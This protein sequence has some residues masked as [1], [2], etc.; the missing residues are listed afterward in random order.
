MEFILRVDEFMGLQIH[1]EKEFITITET[2]LHRKSLNQS[3]AEKIKPKCEGIK[4]VVY[5][6]MAFV[7]G[8]AVYIS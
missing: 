4:V 6:R 8:C 1:S 3:V 7:P 2:V 5:R